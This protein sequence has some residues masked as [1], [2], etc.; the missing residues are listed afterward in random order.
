MS[1]ETFAASLTGVLPATITPFRADFAI[2]DRSLDALVRSLLA[3]RGVTGIVV[4]GVAGEVGSLTAEEQG[5]VVAIAAKAVAGRV[6]VVAGLTA[7]TA[8]GAARLTELAA[9]HGAGGVLVQAPGVFARGA[10]QAPEIALAYFRE[11]AA[12]GVPII[13]FQH[14]IQ[15]ARAYPLPLLLKLLELDHVV[16]VKETVWD[17]ERYESEVR[18]IRRHR[19]ATRVLL[20]NDTILLPCLAFGL[21]DGMLVGFACMAP[22]LIVELYEAV[23]RGDLKAAQATNDRLAPI[24]ELVYAAPPIHYYARMKAAMALMGRLPNAL[25]RPPLLPSPAAEVE[26]LRAALQEQ[27]LIP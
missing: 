3:V 24:T 12:V 17:A 27:K 18:A 13:V 1:T 14:Q 16:A 21:H 11:V 22:E 6:P 10:A 7:E 9:K 8:R 15:T 2:D 4:N 5:Q 25:V 26:R 19:P 23:E 20:A